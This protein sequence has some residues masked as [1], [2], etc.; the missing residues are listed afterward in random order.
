MRRPELGFA[1]RETAL[2]EYKFQVVVFVASRNGKPMTKT[3]DPHG[4]LVENIKQY[5]YDA[6]RVIEK[7]RSQ[8]V[9]LP[10]SQSSWR[11]SLLERAKRGE[12]SIISWQDLW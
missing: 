5:G 7:A 3:L 4:K 10:S 9:Q 12:G 11:R 2:G 8:R 1:A 6:E